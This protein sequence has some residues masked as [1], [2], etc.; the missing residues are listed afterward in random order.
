LTLVVE[1]FAVLFGWVFFLVML[2]VLGF[3]LLRRPR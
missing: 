2:G 3:F 1:G